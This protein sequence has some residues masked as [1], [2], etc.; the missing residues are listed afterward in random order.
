MSFEIRTSECKF[1]KA[2]FFPLFTIFCCRN[3]TDSRGY[4]RCNDSSS[5]DESGSSNERE[6]KTPHRQNRNLG[7]SCGAK[8]QE[9]VLFEL[10]G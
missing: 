1:R 2:A 6:G 9:N 7:S 5:G 3:T 8:D 10:S 4:L